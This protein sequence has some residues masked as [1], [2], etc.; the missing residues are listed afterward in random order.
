M[1]LPGVWGEGKRQGEVGKSC[2]C[3]WGGK[4]IDEIGKN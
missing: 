4:K 1:E 3:V 2:V